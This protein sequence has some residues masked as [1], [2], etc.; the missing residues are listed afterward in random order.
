MNGVFEPTITFDYLS[1]DLNIEFQE[2][3]IKIPSRTYMSGNIFYRPYIF[4]QA[5]TNQVVKNDHIQFC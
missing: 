5:S 2:R 1:K 4:Q 3:N